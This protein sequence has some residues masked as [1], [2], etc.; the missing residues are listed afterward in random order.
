MTKQ[1]LINRTVETLERLPEGRI[2]EVADFADFV[3]KK[4]EEQILQQ[5]IETLM[6]QSDSL[7]FLHE[8]EDLYEANGRVERETNSTICHRNRLTEVVNKSGLTA[9][10][11]RGYSDK[12]SR[13]ILVVG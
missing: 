11:I 9:A 10:F 3:L 2:H 7:A 13:T 1:K 6:S 8:E 5:G 4:Y 12:F